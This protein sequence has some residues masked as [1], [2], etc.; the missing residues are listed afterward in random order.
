MK[1]KEFKAKV[2]I[3]VQNL[4][5]PFDRRVWLEA[6]TLTEAGYRV[7]VISP[8]GK[9]KHILGYEHRCGVH[10]Y[11]YSVPLDARGVLGYA[12]EF[13]YCWCMTAYL[14]LKILHRHGFDI[15]HA[16]NP[17]ETYFLLAKLYKPF[18]RKFIFDHHDLSPEM[19]LAKYPQKK[20][21]R[22][23]RFLTYLELQ[24]FRTADVVIATNESH[25]RIAVKRG[26][27]RPEQVFV[28]RTGPDFERLQIK[29]IRN[30]LKRGKKF[31]VCYLGEMCPQDGVELLIEAVRYLVRDL[32]FEDALFTLVGGGPALPQLEA[33]VKELGLDDSVIFAGR[34][35]DEVL[36]EYLSTADVCV[37]PDPLTEWSDKSTMNKIMEYMAFKKPIVAFDLK[38]NRYSAKQAA[39]YTPPNDTVEFS[40]NILSLLKNKKKRE[41]MGEF[42]FQRVKDELLWDFSKPKLL[43]AYRALQHPKAES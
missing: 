34:V 35:S 36:C 7:S 22:L 23:Y 21:R 2:L 15:I 13:I 27:V 32:C 29:P 39:I 42:G 16:C 18:G 1:K 37:D 17:P 41:K 31:L 28:V 43:D 12:F 19:F 33:Q 25:R 4:P 6:L 14:S 20:G 30:E 24:T 40:K 9:N 8:K 11:R 10:I 26:G 38:E 3:I 5:V